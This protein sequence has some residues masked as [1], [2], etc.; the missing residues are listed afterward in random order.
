MRGVNACFYKIFDNINMKK[1]GSFVYELF[2][3]H[4]HF[5]QSM[6]LFHFIINTQK[7]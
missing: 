7:R 1:M 5:Q 3:P 2:N 4:K 6:K